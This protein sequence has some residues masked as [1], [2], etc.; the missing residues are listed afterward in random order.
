MRCSPIANA[1]RRNYIES[2]SMN[3]SEDRRIWFFRCR[4]DGDDNHMICVEYQTDCKIEASKALRAE[5]GLAA[6][7]SRRLRM[8]F[9]EYCALL[10]CNNEGDHNQKVYQAI[11]R[12][13]FE[14]AAV[15]N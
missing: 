12:V 10:R 6:D 5:Y 14:L 11:Q 13:F 2:E 9:H 15:R 8:T 3:E 4:E 7:E 1:N